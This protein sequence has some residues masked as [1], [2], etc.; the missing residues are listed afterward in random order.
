MFLII[1]G[2]LS[3]AYLGTITIP[4]QVT[5]TASL[6]KEISREIL[7]ATDSTYCIDKLCDVDHRPY[8]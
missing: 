5:S 4:D 3:R 1:N 6:N 7:F 2:N 8:Q